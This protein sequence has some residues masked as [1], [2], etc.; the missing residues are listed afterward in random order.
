MDRRQAVAG[1]RAARLD[2]TMAGVSG[3]FGGAF[4]SPGLGTL[5]VSELAPTPKA[6]YMEGI[7]PQLIAATVAFAVFYG[8]VGTTFLNS[9]AIPVEEFRNQHLL[10]GVGL[11]VAASLLM[12]AFVIIVKL[13]Q[14]VAATVPN[15]FVRGVVGGAL[16]GL[17][18]V[19]FPLTVGAGND[20]LTTVI[21]SS[22]SIS[23]VDARRRRRRE[24]GGD[25]AQPV[26]RVHRRRRA[27]H[28][29][30]AGPPA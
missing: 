13:V 27:A 17:I 4:T 1:Q 29:F 22:A 16:V 11:G 30:V 8:V 23:L 3:G 6:R 25:G 24:D 20:Q 5:I 7:L 12:I 2:A 28:A 9:F 18:A 14:A 26:R 21:D 10:M 19:A 15:G